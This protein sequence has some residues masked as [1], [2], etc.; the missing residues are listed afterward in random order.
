MAFLW[1]KETIRKSDIVMLALTM[2]GLFGVVLGGDGSGTLSTPPIAMWLLYVGLVANPI[3]SG[4]GTVVMRKMKKSG[5]SCV[6]WY[7][8]WSMLFTC[9]IIMLIEGVDSFNVFAKFDIWCWVISFF[10]GATSVYSET[11]RFKALKL[12]KASPL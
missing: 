4:W 1:L 10:T 11:L 6:S 12:H 2:I 3:L 5:D 7:L 8:Q 9:L